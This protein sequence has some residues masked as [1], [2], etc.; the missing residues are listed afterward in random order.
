MCSDAVHFAGA[1]AKANAGNIKAWV[2]FLN[3]HYMATKMG[4]QY[5]YVEQ[6]SGT[7]VIEISY[8]TVNIHLSSHF[9]S[10]II[11]IK[12]ILHI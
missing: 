11:H 9:C 3:C 10:K 8:P 12:L 6:S 5:F 7:K 4:T 1:M 2:K